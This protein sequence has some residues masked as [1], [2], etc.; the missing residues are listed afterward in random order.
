[1]ENTEI[2]VIEN[3]NLKRFGEISE[4][5]VKH[6]KFAIHIGNQTDLYYL[7]DLLCAKKITPSPKAQEKFNPNLNFL[8]VDMQLGC[9]YAI[10]ETYDFCLLKKYVFV[11]KKYLADL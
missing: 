11:S 10:V 1:M 6:E 4:P 2:D 7:L 3:S 9:G 8:L 5:K